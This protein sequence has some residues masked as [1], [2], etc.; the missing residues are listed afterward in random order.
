[1][2]SIYPLLLCIFAFSTA[3]ASCSYQP[4]ATADG[5]YTKDQTCYFNLA[6]AAPFVLNYQV[7]ATTTTT[8]TP[9]Y[10]GT[11]TPTSSIITAAKG[12]YIE[13]LSILLVRNL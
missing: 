10:T 7:S 2:W 3:Q 6:E 1:M 8:V 5:C 4:D 12:V 11:F 13:G 9:T